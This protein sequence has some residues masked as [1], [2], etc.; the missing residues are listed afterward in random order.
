MR[1]DEIRLPHN[2][3][4]RDYQLEALSALDSG[5]KR[6][7]L[8]WH[9]RAG[10]D[11]TAINWVAKELARKPTSALHLLPEYKQAKRAIWR[12]ID[13]HTGKTHLDQAFP[14]PLRAAV[15]STEGFLKLWNGS[16]YQ[17][18][19]FDQID[20]YLGIGPRIVIMSEFAISQHAQRAWN[21]LLPMLLANDGIAIFPYTPRGKN[22]GH[23]LYE[24]HKGNADWFVSLRTVDDTGVI[25]RDAIE[26]EIR[27]GSM[28]HDY[29]QQEFWCSFNAP[30]AGA[31]Y[32][33]MM[34]AAEREGRVTD[35]SW[36][37]SLPVMTWWDIGVDDATVIWFIQ[38][39]RSGEIRCIDYYEAEGE[40]LPHYLSVLEERRGRGWYFSSDGQLVP[41]DF[42]ARSFTS[43]DSPLETARKLGWKMTVIPQAPIDH[44]I[45]LVRRTLPR[46]WFDKTRCKD[47]I[48]HLAEY[49][50]RWSDQ[51]NRFIG[52]L[53][54]EHSHGADAFRIG[55]SGLQDQGYRVLPNP[56]QAAHVQGN[57]MRR[58]GH[59]QHNMG[60]YE[61]HAGRK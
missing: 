1:P 42:A 24:G 43:G 13:P 53:H 35:L 5:I 8:I 52:P 58:G 7:I 39:H 14:E 51:L 36:E 50:K 16:I 47:G 26:Q 4:P 59:V 3:S 29:A 11:T 44:G 40:G 46:C 41:H 38:V 60:G 2:W 25:P 23:E 18:G 15:N 57:M 49:R 30:N 6:A 27:S 10:K 45:D 55:V 22:H 32:G 33:R 37:P 54:D 61:L 12:E 17:I 56:S 19:G 48:R 21:L 31:Y 34:E 20:S 9:R 28:D